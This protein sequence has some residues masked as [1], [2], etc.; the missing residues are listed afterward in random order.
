MESPENPA[1]DTDP[2]LTM[3]SDREMH[4]QALG[5]RLRRSLYM[6]KSDNTPRHLDCL[7]HALMPPNHIT[8]FLLYANGERTKNRIT[9]PADAPV[10]LL[11][12]TNSS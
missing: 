2:M 12:L 8:A 10:P 3:Q 7:L 5:K 1:V 9:N 4:E 11:D 6:F